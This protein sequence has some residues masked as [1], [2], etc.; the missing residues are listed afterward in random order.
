MAMGRR[1]GRWS[2]PT[3]GVVVKPLKIF[4]AERS[5]LVAEALAALFEEFAGDSE[6][7][8]ALSTEE[9]IG[10]ARR[11]QPGLVVL[12]AWIDGDPAT[13]V[14]K[15]RALSPA[16]AVYV[17]ATKYDSHLE[18]RL[19]GAGAAGFRETESLPGTVHTILSESGVAR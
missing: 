4:V 13:T 2:V 17:F 1:A 10:I 19:I 15:V 7:T 9:V 6:I 18:N 8:I 11:E 12:N 5:R 14:R 3:V 16:S